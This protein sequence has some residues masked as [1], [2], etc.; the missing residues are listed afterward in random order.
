MQVVHVIQ[1]VQGGASGAG[2]TCSESV[3]V[4]QQISIFHI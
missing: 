2:G 4:F 3:P 1:A